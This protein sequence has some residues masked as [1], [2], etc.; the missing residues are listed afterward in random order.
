MSSTR[1]TWRPWIGRS[2]SR[3]IVSRSLGGADVRAVSGEVEG[4]GEPLA[5]PPVGRADREGGRRVDPADPVVV[6][7]ARELL[8]GGMAEAHPHVRWPGPAE[9]PRPLVHGPAQ[10]CGD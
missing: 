4:G 6:E 7:E 8:L 10:G 9:K 1:S 5:H 2:M 3:P